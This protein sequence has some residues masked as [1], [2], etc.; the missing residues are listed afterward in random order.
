MANKRDLTEADIRSK[1]ITPALTEAGWDLQK[2]IREEQYFTDGRIRV[3]G[4]VAKREKGKKAD[5]ILYYKRGI[6]LAVIEA[7][8]NKHAVGAGLQQALDYGDILDIP[9]VYSSNGDGFVE[10]DRT[11]SDGEIIQEIG[12]D[13]FPS[14]Q[15][16]WN[17]YAEAKGLDK[18]QEKL[19]KQPYHFEQGGRTLRYYQE[20][21][22]NRTIEA[23][24]KGLD[25]ILLVM[26]TGTGKTITAFQII[27][28]LWKSGENKRILFLADRNILVDDPI[29][30][31]FGSLKDVVHKIQRGNVSKA[32]QI[33]FA[34]YQAV[35]GNEDYADVFKEYSPD[36]FD[37]IIIDE[38]HRGS[39]A[40]DSA[41]RR[42]LEYFDS[43]THIGLTAT[44][45]ETNTVSNIDYF[46]EPIYTYSLK[47][48]IADGFLA[49]YKVVRF[50]ID[51]DAEG[52]R[53][54]DGF[55]DKHGN[56]IPD[57]EYN[58]KDYDRNL[59]LEKRTELV[60]RK[61]TEFLKETDRYAKTIVF[62]IDIDHAERM[63]QALM[64]L[65]ADLVAKDS[66]Y[67]MRI[68]GDEQ[69]GKMELDNFMD[70]E[71]PYPV[72]A[73]TSKLLTTGVDI[74]TCKFIVLDAN[75]GSMTEF[76]QIIGRGTR[77][78]EDYGKMY[79]T[80]MDF[81]N[82]TRHFA[83]P[84]FDG[85]PVQA[86]TFGPDDNPAED[87][88]K[89]DEELGDMVHE[90]GDPWENMD[91]TGGEIEDGEVKR[92]YVDNVEVKLLNQRIQYYDDDGKLVTESL[93]DY[94][95][96]KINEKYGSL[97]DFLRK[98]KDSEK[99]QA[100][101]EELEESGVVFEE[102][103]KVV[104][105]DLDP[106]D[107]ICHVAFEQPALTRQ[108]RANNVKKRN[109]FGKYSGT[110][111]EVLEGLLEKYEDEGL[112]NLEDVNILRLDPFNNM[113]TPMEII[114]EFGG[115]DEYL[116]AIH[117]IEDELY[118]SA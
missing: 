76:K 38:C 43:A 59:I 36:F 113:G 12:L 25:R 109:Y 74:P 1:F 33:Y 42:V 75:I 70:E 34:L 8:D 95:R 41:W 13:E 30:K 29:R 103:K 27:W 14:P 116:K 71:E 80:I 105:K 60:A 35:T 65:N 99:K 115:K 46:G 16:L 85:E 31:Y 11:K 73:T 72:I 104:D 7:K 101:V 45:K 69:A 55:T 3:K 6:P 51:K 91:D 117:E 52:W 9:F 4:S 94:S 24:A 66:R 108:E 100:I 102:L 98:W 89:E 106:F 32:H 50:T 19:V 107:L 39:A 18:E 90:E 56:V 57:R 63:R 22:V 118:K 40:A 53:P 84:D 37:L 110:A 96:K 23:I 44:P 112:E 82:V 17:R 88:I 58:Q 2:Q 86:A 87:I 79:F 48:G 68:T 26:A 97:D 49:P 54:V 62:C 15:E 111:K 78:S 77:I 92:F 21:A 47:Q 93:K 20:I 61:V 83:D 81:R 10:Q 67:V 64:N 28:R 114:Q 5:Y